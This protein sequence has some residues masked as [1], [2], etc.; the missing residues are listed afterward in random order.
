MTDQTA[1][2]GAL[3]ERVLHASLQA[4]AAGQ[5]YPVVHGAP[6]AETFGLVADAFYQML[7][8][9]PAAAWRVPV[10]R[11]LD[12]QQ[13]VGHLIGVEEDL[14][15]ALGG[16][17]MVA[18][19]DHILATQ[20]AVDRQA[21]REP[22]L[23][24]RDWR[25][26]VDQ[27]LSLIAAYGDLGAVVEVHGIRLPLG[28]LLIAR[29]FEVWTHDNDIRAATGQPPTAPDQRALRPMTDLAVSL[30]PTATTR[31]GLSD[32]T[33]VHLVLTGPGGGTWDLALGQAAVSDA[34]AA[35]SAVAIVADAVGF[36]RLVAN[37]AAVASLD[38]H[39]TGDQGRAAAVLAAAST[40]ALD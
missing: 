20:P 31:A 19:A 34:G 35:P 24:L 40:L 26:A 3:R 10:I 18:T 30:W 27:T 28:E 12:A 23:T 7:S 6:P 1:V 39:V 29:S 2:P 17:R 11:N 9:L 13:L 22:A 5:S 16:D 25:L 38:L 37:R 4:R 32:R 33:S 36:C 15:R 21:G 14:Q 8:S